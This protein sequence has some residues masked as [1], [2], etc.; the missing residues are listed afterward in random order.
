M[1]AHKKFRGRRVA[2]AR[3]LA[4]PLLLAGCGREQRISAPATSPPR[5]LP[6]LIPTRN[7]PTASALPAPAPSGN[8]QDTGWLAGAQGVQLRHLRV[9]VEHAQAQVPL[10]AVRLDPAQLQLRVG[11]DPQQPRLLRSWFTA[12]RPVLAINGGYFD[13]DYH[14]TALVVQDGVANGESYEGFGGMLAVHQDGT[15]ELRPL[16][17]IPYDPAESLAHA[18]Q[19]SPMLVFPGG[20][21]ADLQEDGQRARRSV[22][23]IDQHGYL[24]FIAGPTSGLTLLEL[25][26]WLANSDLEI[27]RAL[28]LDGGSSTGLF[29]ASGSLN[30]AID[31]FSPLPIVILAGKQP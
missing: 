26:T 18:I 11:Y 9:P 8:S 3:L 14:S 25:A 1:G 21:P 6:T 4:A 2:L 19:S 12:E 17:D 27:D 20:I 13:A 29:L 28:N 31:S 23:A 30:E 10:V 5:I 16:R 7:L 22:V 15:V 24:L